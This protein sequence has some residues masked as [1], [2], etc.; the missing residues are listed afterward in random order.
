MLSTQV[1]LAALLVW[2]ALMFGVAL[3]GERR[4]KAFARSWNIVYA[5]SLA[6]HCTSWTFYGTVTQASRSGWWLPPTFIGAI[7]LYIFALDILLRLVRLAREH[8]ASSLADLISARLGRHSGLAAL[9]TLVMLLGIVPYIALQLKAVAMSYGVLAQRPQTAPIWQ[10]SALYIA[11]A[12][13]LFTML[14]GTRRANAVA[15]NRGLVL[16][17]AFESLFK[18]AAMLALGTLVFDAPAV[19]AAVNP[20]ASDTR[21]FP[22]LI[23]LGALAMFTLPHQFHAGVVEC[24]DPRHLKTARWLFPLYMVLIALPILPLA[25]LGDA[26][27][28][29]AGVPSD[30]YMLALP[31]SQGRS[32]LTLLAFMGGLSAATSMV[33]VATLSLSLMIANHFIAPLRVRAGWGRGAGDL[34]GEVLTLRRLSILAVILLGW[35]YSRMLGSTALA[36]IGALSFS[37]LAELAPA[38]LI[39]VYRPALGARAAAAGLV[40]G[41]LVWLYV[42]FMPAILGQADWVHDGPF[43]VAI[44]APTNALG[45]GAWSTLARAVSLSLAANILV[46]ALTV[47]LDRGRA[48]PQSAQRPL[49]VAELRRLAARF[50]APER[51]DSLLSLQT[52]KQPVAAATLAAVEHELSAVIGSSSARLLVDVAKRNRADQLDTVAA[53]VGEASQNLRFSQRVLEAALENMSQGICVV[54][55]ALNVVAW[56]HRY[57]QLFD[58]PLNLLS[59]G[60]PVVELIRHNVAAGVIGPGDVETRVLHRLAQMQ[61]GTPHVS[62]RRFPDGSVIEIRGNP[63]PGG[64]YVATFGDVSAFR[65]AQE[66][67]TRANETLEARVATRT[68]ELQAVTREAQQANEAKTRFLAAVSHDLLQPLHA[69]QLFAHNLGARIELPQRDML[70]H[71]DGALAATESLLAGLLDIARLDGGRLQAQPR[72]FALAE[73][74]DPLAAEFAVLAGE[75]G[76]RLDAVATRTWVHSDAQLLRRILQ[77]FLGNALRHTERGRIVFGCRRAGAQLRIE[78]WDTGPGIA[79]SERSA[80]FEEFRRGAQASSQGLGLGLAIAD[81]IAKL[82]DHPLSLRSW[83]GRGSVF[84][85]SVPMAPAAYVATDR[86]ESTNVAAGA[87]LHSA[88]AGT[89]LLVDNEPQAL[90]ALQLLLEGWGWQVVA[91][92]DAASALALAHATRPDVAILDYHLDGG[93]TGLQL[94]TLLQRAHGD[95]A[96]I[97]LTADRDVSLREQAQEQGIAVLYKPLKPPA[98]HQ[99]LQHLG[100]AITI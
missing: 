25:R 36:D 28:A 77:N 1:V 79:D 19:A 91:A 27:L 88:R 31:L 65:Q 97:M 43:G 58:Y 2:L 34:R 78:V 61:A 46:V 4:D 20:A 6:V 85:L 39:A 64:G 16:A 81:R 13:A 57:A 83:P 14:F 75:R 32:G 33:V 87:L 52:P 76:L 49:S 50:L 99:A 9:V 15:H 22:C 10:D 8:N 55:A 26:R 100:D 59:V 11:L 23:L 3:Y 18:L 69:A 53:I 48:A 35:I 84:A 29:A 89:A 51:I 62:E 37:A 93:S 17:L 86:I 60:R 30:L 67:L 95:I 54:D 63:M 92:R 66:G 80:I 5:L 96:T 38:T 21:G 45:L 56:N 7:L 47:W 73:V 74:L 24:R 72:D 41:T 42:V 68:R 70:R 40:A 98:L 12:M 44:L 82:L 71:L 94:H 90:K